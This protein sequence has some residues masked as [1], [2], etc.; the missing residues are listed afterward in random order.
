ME[1]QSA[2]SFIKTGYRVAIKNL[3][4]IA[5]AYLTYKAIKSKN[6][7]S[8]FAKTAAVLQYLALSKAIENSEKADIRYWSSL[9]NS[10]QMGFVNLLPGKYKLEIRKMRNSSVASKIK[11]EPL[12]VSKDKNT[13]LVNV[14][15]K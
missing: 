15:S 13:F 2:S 10:I 12:I 8:F 6:G 5:T 4:A 1:K 9:P 7:N 11:L 14:S 3:A